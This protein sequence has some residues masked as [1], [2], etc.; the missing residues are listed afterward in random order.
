MTGIAELLDIDLDQRGVRI[1]Q[2]AQVGPT[3]F[4]RLADA[5]GIGW[6]CLADG[7]PA[8]QNYK[9]AV[10]RLL[11]S[12][13][14]AKHVLTLAE[15]TIET[16]LCVAGFGAVYESNISTQKRGQVT[17]PTGSV[18]YWAQVCR[19]Q[20]NSKGKEALALEV[21]EAVRAKGGKSAVPPT[22]KGVLD[23]VLQLA[24]RG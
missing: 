14:E 23:A 15:S 12:R 5:L 8:G 10:A 1:V 6:F 21:L 11:D 3:T 17:A 4:V 20:S 16:H 24:S 18:A 9:G 2:Y 22:L 19:A 13:M 7:D